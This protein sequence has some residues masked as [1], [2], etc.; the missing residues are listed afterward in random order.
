[1]K[2]CPTLCS[3]PEGA[4]CEG[5]EDKEKIGEEKRRREIGKI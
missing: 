1:V 5:L 3:A 2:R 4:R